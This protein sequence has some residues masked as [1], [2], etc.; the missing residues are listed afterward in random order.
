MYLCSFKTTEEKTS[1]L[2]YMV[3]AI[4]WTVNKSN[5]WPTVSDI[6]VVLYRKHYIL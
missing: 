1:T 2:F 5:E 4:H 6:S 3:A